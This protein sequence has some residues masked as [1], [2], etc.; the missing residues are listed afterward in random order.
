MSYT[1][2]FAEHMC[3]R[4][5]DYTLSCTHAT[6]AL[7]FCKLA[8][9]SLNQI[10]TLMSRHLGYLSVSP[11]TR[12]KHS[13]PLSSPTEAQEFGSKAGLGLSMGLFDDI[14]VTADNGAAR[15]YLDLRNIWW[16]D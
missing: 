8:E 9:Y 1:F 2:Y 6:T 13:F 11:A 14:H 4:G 16:F 15:S 12:S 3:C 5:L 10:L 7:C